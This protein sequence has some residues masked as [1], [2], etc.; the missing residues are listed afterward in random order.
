MQKGAQACRLAPFCV[1]FFLLFGDTKKNQLIE[2]AGGSIRPHDNS[3]NNKL[4][5]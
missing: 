5:L 2:R 4:I 3:F 1:F